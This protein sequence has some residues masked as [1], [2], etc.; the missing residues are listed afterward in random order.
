MRTRGGAAVRKRGRE[1]SGEP[2][3]ANPVVLDS[4][5][6]GLRG[7]NSVLR[8]PPACGVWVWRP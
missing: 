5:P 4:Q 1:A 2:G 3:P 7:D 8:E 6:P